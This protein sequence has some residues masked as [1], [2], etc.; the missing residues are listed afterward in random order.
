MQIND[1]LKQ[2]EKSQQKK[3]F[4]DR[5][6]KKGLFLKEKRQSNHIIASAKNG[7]H[8]TFIM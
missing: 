5:T 4:T 6:E 8:Q 2:E 3:K 7:Q 1:E